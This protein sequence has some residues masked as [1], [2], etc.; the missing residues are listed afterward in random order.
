[1]ET[2][3]KLVVFSA[4]AFVFILL[5]A[6]FIGDFA[7]ASNMAFIGMLVLIVPYS[8]YKFIERKKIMSYERSFPLFLR[9]ISESQRSGLSTIQSIQMAAKSD[10]GELTEE[11]KRMGNQLSWN[12]TL[13]NVLKSFSTRMKRSRIITR[14][15]LVIDE[16]NKSG[17]NIE[18]TIDSLAEN[19]EM[20]KELQE[21]KRTLLNQ[22]V[23][24]MYAIFLIFLGISIA[25]IK[26]L[27]PMLQMELGT[28]TGSMAGL[29]GLGMFSPNPCISCLSQSDP[30]CFSC[31]LFLSVATTFG[32]GE[33][34]DPTAYYKALFF[35]MVIVQGFFGGLIVGQISSESVIPGIKH[36]IVMLLIGAFAFIAVIKLGFV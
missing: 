25:L 29:S 23:L 18:D 27:I 7:I 30:G 28:E 8:A 20:N 9:D 17:G 34:E 31:D 14:S 24:M 36:S 26:F 16:A 5:I 12:I 3:I 1:M 6:V 4:M 21:E 11:I 2:E 35:S 22:Q 10:Y 15:L 19:I 13:T 33:R 32:F